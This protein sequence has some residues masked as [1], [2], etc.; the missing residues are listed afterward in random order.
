MKN[1]SQGILIT[2]LLF[3]GACSNTKK[4]AESTVQEVQDTLPCCRSTP[5]T[6]KR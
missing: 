3:L 6:F 5:M 4:S 1:R 2:N